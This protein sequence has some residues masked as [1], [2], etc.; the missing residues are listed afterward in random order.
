MDVGVRELKARLSEYLDLAARGE[1][2]RVTER[3]RPKAM[4]VPI[5][6]RVR[7]DDGVAEGWVTPPTRRGL[8]PARRAASARSVAEV[9]SEDRGA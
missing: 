7:V 3:G 9:L 4:L 2:V 1:V 6:G 8:G 5:P